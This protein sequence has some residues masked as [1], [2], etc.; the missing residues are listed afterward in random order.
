M[1]LQTL[2]KK[3]NKLVAGTVNLGQATLAP[4]SGNK[5]A[6]ISSDLKMCKDADKTG[7]PALRAT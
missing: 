4:I 6:Y 1:V 3:Q 7:R 2:L 5:Q